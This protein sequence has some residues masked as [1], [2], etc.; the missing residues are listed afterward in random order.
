LELGN[1]CGGVEERDGW[2][3]REGG[4]EERGDGLKVS[5]CEDPVCKSSNYVSE[6]QKPRC[7]RKDDVEHCESLV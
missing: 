1:S 2:R 5:E 4:N 7:E 3:S 6:V